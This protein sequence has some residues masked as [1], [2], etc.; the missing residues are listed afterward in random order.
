MLRHPP[1]PPLFPHPPLSR[2][3]PPLP[4]DERLDTGPRRAIKWRHARGPSGRRNAVTQPF[5]L[6]VPDELTQER[7]VGRV[8]EP[9]GFETAGGNEDHPARRHRRGR[10]PTDV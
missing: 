3:S 9:Q 7:R 6:R 10:Q 4:F 5:E 2:S 8:E 1:T